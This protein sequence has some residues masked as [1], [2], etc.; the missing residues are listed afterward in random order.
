[1]N[2]RNDLRLEAEIRLA[3]CGLT[4]PI[5]MH[6]AVGQWIC[7]TRRD[8]TEHKLWYTFPPLQAFHIKQSRHVIAVLISTQRFGKVCKNV[9][10]KNIIQ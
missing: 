7:K 3:R 8:F 5:Y 9:L 6:M 10:G 2:V 1:M 4:M